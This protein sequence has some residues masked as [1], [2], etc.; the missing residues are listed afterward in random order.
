MIFTKALRRDLAN[1][2]GVVFATLFTMLLTTTLIRM[3][4]R[5]AGGKVRHRRASCR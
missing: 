4:G 1:L 3:L 2:A 5:A